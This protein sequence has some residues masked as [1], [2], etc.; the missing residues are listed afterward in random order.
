M[1]CTIGNWLLEGESYAILDKIEAD[2]LQ[3]AKKWNR[4]W[5]IQHQRSLNVKILAT[6]GSSAPVM[7]ISKDGNSH[8]KHVRAE[9]KDEKPD[10]SDFYRNIGVW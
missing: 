2:L 4:T 9:Y 3:A 1:A 6:N 8:L 10:A 5:I 7:C